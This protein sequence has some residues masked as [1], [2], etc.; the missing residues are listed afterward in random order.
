MRVARGNGLRNAW[1]TQG[2]RLGRTLSESAWTLVSSLFFC[3][4]VRWWHLSIFT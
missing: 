3:S 2:E 1:V 4:Q